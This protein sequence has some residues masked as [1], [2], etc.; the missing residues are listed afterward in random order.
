M[1]FAEAAALNGGVILAALWGVPFLAVGLYLAVGRF[2]VKARKRQKTLY[3]VT[4]QRVIEKSGDTVRSIFLTR[5][6]LLEVTSGGVPREESS[7]ARSMA[8]LE[9]MQILAW[10]GLVALVAI[11][12]WRSSIS[13]TPLPWAG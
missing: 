9:C 6:P 13:P 5:L 7:L 8:W 12:P 2:V 10:I 1:S 11:Y 3:A 4:D